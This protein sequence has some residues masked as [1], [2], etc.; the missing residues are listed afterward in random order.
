LLKDL[1]LT[2]VRCKIVFVIS[3]PPIHFEDQYDDFNDDDK[4]ATCID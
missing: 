2:K 4:Y 3:I 1:S